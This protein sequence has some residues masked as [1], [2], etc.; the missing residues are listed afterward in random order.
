MNDVPAGPA[1]ECAGCEFE[2]SRGEYVHRVWFCTEC[3]LAMARSDKN[4][5]VRENI[6]QKE[7]IGELAHENIVLGNRVE[8]LKELEQQAGNVLAVIHRDG[9]HYISKHGWKKACEDAKNMIPKERQE[10]E[11][12]RYEK[13]HPNRSGWGN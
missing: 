10:L 1:L 11:Q 7:R 9:G 3:L 13:K 2:R 8:V 12:L 6:Q 4:Q 5:Y